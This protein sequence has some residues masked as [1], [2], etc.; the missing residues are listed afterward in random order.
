MDLGEA[1]EP[2]LSWA[3]SRRISPAWYYLGGAAAFALFMCVIG[4]WIG[5]A[6]AQDTQPVEA[7]AP[8]QPIT[9]PSPPTGLTAP[10]ASLYSG[11][12]PGFDP[13]D[14]GMVSIRSTPP[15]AV[16]SVRTQ[17]AGGAPNAPVAANATPWPAPPPVA[18]GPASGTVAQQSVGPPTRVIYRS[19]P[20]PYPWMPATPPPAKPALPAAS[21]TTAVVSLR[22]DSPHPIEI[23]VEGGVARSAFVSAGSTI[24]LTLPPGSYQLRARG[25]GVSSMSSTLS[26][27][28]KG[29]YAI[30]VNRRKEGDRDALVITEPAID[31]DS[32]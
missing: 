18:A 23:T 19:G 25:S 21:E 5:R 15:R 31:G 30:A 9:L 12:D 7:S 24:P 10:S 3:L 29:T 13:P 20:T 22:N 32:Q 8:P 4:F 1:R 6:S 16:R 26:L 17:D 11:A 28:A 14:P 2:T 27:A